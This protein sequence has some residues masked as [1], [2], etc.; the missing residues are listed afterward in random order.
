ML[1]R[2]VRQLV[3]PACRGPLDTIYPAR[4]GGGRLRF[5]D[6]TCRACHAPYALRDGVGRFAAPQ[7]GGGDW[8][9]DPASEGLL[10]HDEDWGIYLGSLPPGVPEAYERVLE[11]LEDDVAQM[12]GLIVDLAVG[13][14][15]LLRRLAPR[16]SSPQLLLGVDTDAGRLLSCQSELRRER[17]SANVSMAEVD[18]AHLPLPDHSVSGVVSF[19][20]PF[21]LRQGRAVLKEMARVLRP[22]GL[23][24]FSTL[25]AREGSLTVRQAR[26]QGLD[27]LLTERRLRA[28]LAR[29]GLL[30]ERWEVVGEGEAWRRNPF[31]PLPLEGDPYQY[32]LV[33]ARAGTARTTPRRRRKAGNS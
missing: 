24:A 20:G 1:E 33:Q 14:G 30:P 19:F 8:R 17:H 16:T 28:A 6:L 26:R 21:G 25:L 7:E 15:L 9:P 3:C 29:A 27:E 22:G 11:A 5:A 18:P 10:S 23:F 12:P 32:V 4:K 31:D 13:R 2:V